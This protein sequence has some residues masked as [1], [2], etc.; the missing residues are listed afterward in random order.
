MEKNFY[1]YAYLRKGDRTPYYIG[2]GRGKRAY[3]RYTHRVKVPDDRDRI[4]FLKENVSEKVEE[5]TQEHE[6]LV[7]EADIKNDL[8]EFGVDTHSPDLFNNE[9][10]NSSSDELLSPE[11]EDS[12]DDLEIPA[13]LRRQKN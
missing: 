8:S 2:K 13:F 6:N 10:I 11:N 4:I 7:N 9:S 5:T 1:T 3:D 12:E